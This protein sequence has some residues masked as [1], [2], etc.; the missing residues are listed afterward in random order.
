MSCPVREPATTDLFPIEPSTAASFSRHIIPA[1]L[2]PT[3]R[4]IAAVA[5][6]HHQHT[7]PT[8]LRL[9]RTVHYSQNTMPAVT[10]PP[11]A[12]YHPQHMALIRTNLPLYSGTSYT[13]PVPITESPYGQHRLPLEPSSGSD[14]WNDEAQTLYNQLRSLGYH[15]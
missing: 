15:I 10:G 8:E 6:H 7:R 2:M 5:A 9:P 3:E 11:Q 14:N 13:P 1:C 4:S 12:I